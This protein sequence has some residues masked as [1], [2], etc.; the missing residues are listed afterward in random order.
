MSTFTLLVPFCFRFHGGFDHERSSTGLG[1]QI[2]YNSM[3]IF[4]ECGGN[5]SDE[6]GALFSPSYPNTYP[7]LTE[8]IYLVSQPTGSFIS[9]AFKAMDI[10]CHGTTSDFIE[11]RDGSSH[12]SP[13]MGRFCGKMGTFLNTTQNHLRVRLVKKLEHLQGRKNLLLETCRF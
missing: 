5:F 7:E 12:D 6:S 10:D 1:F 2:E 9:I 8:C 4:T 3:E 13:L 11:M